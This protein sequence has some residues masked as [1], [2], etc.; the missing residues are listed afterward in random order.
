[1]TPE[2]RQKV[3]S[4]RGSCARRHRHD[5]KCGLSLAAVA[6]RLNAENVPTVTPGARW[7]VATVRRVLKSL[8]Y[9]AELAERR[10]PAV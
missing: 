8:E 9:E 1:M 6:E 10:Q 5:G 4:L 2:I 3:A 7:H